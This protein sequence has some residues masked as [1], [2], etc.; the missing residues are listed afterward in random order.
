MWLTSDEKF[1]RLIYLL[2]PDGLDLIGDIECSKFPPETGAGPP[3][4]AVMYLLVF[5]PIHHSID[6]PK[7]FNYSDLSTGTRR[8]LKIIVSLLFDSSAVMLLEH[9]EDGIHAGLLKSLIDIM[10]D[11]IGNRQ[12][13]MTSH[14][15]TL[16]NELDPDQVRFVTMDESQTH[17]RALKP[18][19]KKA[20]RQYMSEKGTF[21]EFVE[22]V[23]ANEAAK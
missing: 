16:L 7:G 21:A 22:L 12:I 1:G 10:K 13:I 8:T 3:L 4:L 19:E 11:N 20:A 17:V 2:G 15:Q 9:P 18:N 5:K 6:G 14:S 23:E